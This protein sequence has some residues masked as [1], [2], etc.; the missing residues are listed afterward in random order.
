MKTILVTGSTDGI[1]LETA[2]VLARNG[3]EVVVH[4][5]SEKKVQ[6]ARDVIRETAPDAVLQTVHA[7]FADLDAV[8]RMA[9]VLSTS[10]PKLDVLINNAGVFM[11]ERRI[12]KAG[13]EMTLT[14]NYIAPFLLTVLLL[15]LLKRSPDPRVVTVTS[16]AHT[17]GRIDFDDLNAERYFDPDHAYASSKLAGA[18]FA[19]ELARREPWLASNSLHPGVIDTKLLHAGFSD[20][21]DSVAAGART[22]VYLA[23]SPEVKGISGKYFDNCAVDRPAPQVMDSELARQLWEWTGN[24]VSRFLPRGKRHGNSQKNPV[25]QLPGTEGWRNRL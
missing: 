2:L 10:L 1:G 6:R 14:V 7:D 12:S 9:Q 4:G 18:L 5:R 24:A 19:R 21:G 8:A 3:H 16:Y 23:T 11:T 17:R 20:K 22:S 13:F 15:P 25:K